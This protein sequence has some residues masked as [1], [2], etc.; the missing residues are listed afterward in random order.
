[1]ATGEPSAGLTRCE[2][3][4]GIAQRTGERPLFV[5]FVV[6]GVRAALAL[7]RPE[8]AARWLEASRAHLRG[9]AMAEAA[10]AHAQGLVQLAEGHL[11]AAREGLEAAVEG[12][13]RRG[14]VWET[15]GSRLDLAQSLIRSNRHQEAAGLIASVHD[16]AV[17]LGRD[18]LIGRAEELNVLVHSRPSLHQPGDP[19]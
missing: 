19:P 4:L 10:L 1:R 12:W 8:D 13:Q 2:E 11:A 18:P 16:T 6:T 7:H 9:W 3:A 5:P 15:S 17:S 14:R